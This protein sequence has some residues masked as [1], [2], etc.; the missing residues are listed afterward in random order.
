MPFPNAPLTA[1]RF[2]Y[3]LEREALHEPRFET[4]KHDFETHRYRLKPPITFTFCCE[5]ARMSGNFRESMINR[6]QLL[7]EQVAAILPCWLSKM[8]HGGA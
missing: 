3:S 8:F 6:P 2:V 5:N 1:R 7:I 4:G